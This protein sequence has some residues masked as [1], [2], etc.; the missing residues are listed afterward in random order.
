MLPEDLRYKFYVM[1]RGFRDENFS[2]LFGIDNFVRQSRRQAKGWRSGSR[3]SR[4]SRSGLPAHITTAFWTF[5]CG[6]S[7][8]YWSMQSFTKKNRGPEPEDEGGDGVL[9]DRGTEVKAC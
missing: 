7:L 5:L 6:A 2:R 9:I 1:R 4:R 8:S 3:R